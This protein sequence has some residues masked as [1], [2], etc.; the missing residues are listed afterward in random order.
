[1]VGRPEDAEWASCFK[2]CWLA[3]GGNTVVACAVSSCSRCRQIAT[4]RHLSNGAQHHQQN[5]R[6]RFWFVGL[7]STNTLAARQQSIAIVTT[8]SLTLWARDC[9]EC[10]ESYSS[11]GTGI[12]LSPV[13]S[14]RYRCSLRHSNASPTSQRNKKTF[15]KCYS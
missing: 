13:I 3:L 7:A 11:H 5:A 10:M 12:V 8:C 1:M 14:H 9:G 2:P 6:S 15:T 4:A